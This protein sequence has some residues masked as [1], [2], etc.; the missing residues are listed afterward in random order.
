MT[1]AFTGRAG[2]RWEHSWQADLGLRD[3]TASL[4]LGLPP[5]RTAVCTS[6]GEG[7]RERTG[8]GMMSHDTST[9]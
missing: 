7:E 8:M 3:E 9:L 6:T 2:P 4:S 1:Q 5:Q